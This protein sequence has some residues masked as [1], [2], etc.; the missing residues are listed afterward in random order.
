MLNDESKHEQQAIAPQ[1]LKISAAAVARAAGVSPATVSYVMN[2]RP[3]VSADTR[4]HVLAVARKLGFEI[5]RSLE[6]GDQQRVI[7]LILSNIA[8]PFYPELS[9]A[10]SEAAQQQGY[11]VFLS[12]TRDDQESLSSAV[13]AMLDRE[14]QGVA[15]AVARSDN[16]SAVRRLRQAKVPMVQL[17][18]SF[19]HVEA[20]FVGIDDR[21]AGVAMMRHALEHQRWPIATVIGPRTSSASAHRE[22]GFV[23]EARRAGVTI[24]GALR[25]SAPLSMESGREAARVLFASANPPRFILCGSDV[26]ALGVMSE[27]LDAGLRVPED[28]AISG[29]D[30]IDISAT[31]MI[32]L[33]SIVQ[34]RRE[35]SFR[36]VDLLI[37]HIEHPERAVS[38][39]TL[40]FG[41]Q[42]GTSCGCTPKGKRK[43]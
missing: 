17:S 33:T 20:D 15:I 8:N 19:Q 34:P 43:T 13:E 7:G 2:R 39:V 30:G 4:D 22:E 3:G 18:R 29:F 37:D 32:G 40:P 42:R 41:V 6:R 16:A 12:H 26:L 23:S 10:F 27:A 35:M 9:V 24:P 31:P 5:D 36:A 11:D 21:A 25:V 28:V 38:R 1:R 14:V